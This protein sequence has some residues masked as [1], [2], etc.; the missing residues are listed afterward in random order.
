MGRIG[1]VSPYG[2]RI[3]N[4]GEVGLVTSY[5]DKQRVQIEQVF[6]DLDLLRQQVARCPN[7]IHVP[8]DCRTQFAVEGSTR[9]QVC[10]PA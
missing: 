9:A 1:P 2:P 8:P 10:S 7:V 3:V 4:M 5:K 6:I